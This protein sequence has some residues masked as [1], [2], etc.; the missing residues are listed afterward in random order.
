[1]PKHKQPLNAKQELFIRMSARAKSRAEILREVFGLE[2]GKDDPRTIN[3]ADV[4]MTRWRK[5]PE[6][7]TVWK[8]E[9]R[10]VL[11]DSA[12]LAMQVLNKQL[13]SED[14]PWLQNKAANDLLNYGKG[15]I[16]GD[17]ERT[18]HVQI[19]GMPDLGSPDQDE[20]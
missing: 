10:R 7:E 4:Q 2:L 9:I 5:L 14:I 17:E 3:N 15:Q 16:Y 8:D 18:V 20:S 13:I 19:A 12:G 6:F 1:M 11:L